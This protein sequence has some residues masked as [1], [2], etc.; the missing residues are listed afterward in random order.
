[1]D[2]R[3]ASYV[4]RVSSISSW[5]VGVSSIKRL[6]RSSRSA[7][8]FMA[9]ARSKGRGGAGT[10]SVDEGRHHDVGQARHA[11]EVVAVLHEPDREEREGQVAR[12]IDPERRR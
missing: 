3:S 5:K 8:L 9:A 11:L 6:R 10:G 4:E 7:R 1:M 12:G 2:S